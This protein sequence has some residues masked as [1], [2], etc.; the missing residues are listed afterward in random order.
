MKAARTFTDDIYEDDFTIELK[1]L[2]HLTVQ[3]TGTTDIIV[4]GKGVI[5]INGYFNIPPSG[6]LPMEAKILK[7]TGVT[8]A[9]VT[10]SHLT[11]KSC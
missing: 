2:I 3:N 9:Y 4:N 1:N 8:K 10:R 11:S 5:P 6:D 7:F